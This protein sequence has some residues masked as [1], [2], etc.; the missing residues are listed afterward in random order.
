[1]AFLGKKGKEEMGMESRGI[2]TGC[3]NSQDIAANDQDSTTL[4]TSGGQGQIK[5]ITL[6]ISSPQIC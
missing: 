6:K 5:H 3:V 4:G 1:M 2:H